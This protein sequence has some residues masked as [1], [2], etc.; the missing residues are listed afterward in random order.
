MKQNTL[1]PFEGSTKARKRRGR[2]NSGGNYSG[3]GMKGQGSRTGGGVRP[4]FEGGQTP[5]VRRMPKMKGFK[6]PN[7]VTYVAVNLNQLNAFKEGEA[8]NVDSL[9]A[10]NVIKRILPVK[11][12]A[13]G[14]IKVALKITVNRASQAAIEKIKKAGGEVMV[15]ETASEEAAA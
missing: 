2:G 9:K 5:L 6:S 15:L 11:L 12:L 13:T 1:S 4:G 14:E 10:K 7:K 8:V 3:R